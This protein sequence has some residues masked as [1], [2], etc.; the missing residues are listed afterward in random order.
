MRDSRIKEI[1]CIVTN[2]S[3]HN[4]VVVV[5]KTY[6]GKVG[7]GCG[8]F[9]FRPMSVKNVVD[10]YLTPLLINQDSKNISDLWNMMYY[11]SYWRN[12]PILNNAIS[13]I[14]MALWDIKAQYANMPLYELLGGKVRNEIELYAHAEG[15]TIE[16]VI[17]NVGVL[18][19]EGYRYIRCQLGLYGGSEKQV[20]EEDCILQGEYYNS[21]HYVNQTVE[22]FKK[23]REVYG[24][25][26]QL[27]HDIH[28][29]LNPQESLRMIRQLEKYDLYFIE[30]P[31]STE[32]LDWL[33][34]IRQISSTPIAIGE[35]F[36]NPNE[37]VPIISNKEIDYL[38]IHVSQVGG[39]T[40]ILKI[41]SLCA[42]NGVDIVWHTPSDISPIGAAVNAHLNF[43]FSNVVLMEYQQTNEEIEA[44]FPG[45]LIPKNG[46]MKL[47]DKPGIGVGIDVALAT[48]HPN[49]YRKHPWVT[50][51]RTDGTL[52]TP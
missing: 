33:K 6:D 23:L 27:L 52:H 13:A 15:E 25:E 41:V 18:I 20:K 50:S 47:N 19:Q 9:Q 48:K 36:N 37:F 5:I 2:P 26:I 51:R 42:L 22:L 45:T 39:V 16:E 10:D 44:V 46:R 1:E 8:T 28:E 29:R 35:L 43:A 4:Y 11:S 7:Y 32:N 24:Y 40:P 31:V 30:D 17:E 14:D 3:R 34:R 49:R 21:V 38:R 12:G